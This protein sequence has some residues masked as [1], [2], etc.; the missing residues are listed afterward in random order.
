VNVYGRR[1]LPLMTAANAAKLSCKPLILL[2]GAP[3]GT[4]TRVVAA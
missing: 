1:F 4:R 2:A 3:E